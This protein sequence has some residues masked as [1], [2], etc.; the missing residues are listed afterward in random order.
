MRTS[1]PMLGNLLPLELA[2]SVVEVVV[3]SADLRKK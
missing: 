1:A 3:G 2:I